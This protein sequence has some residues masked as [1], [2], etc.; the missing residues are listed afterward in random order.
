MNFP[1]L[2]NRTVKDSIVA[3]GLGKKGHNNPSFIL[4][5]GFIVNK[6]GFVLTAN[7]V[8]IEI[9][10]LLKHYPD[11]EFASFWI[12]IEHNRITVNKLICENVAIMI[13]DKDSEYYIQEEVDIALMIPKIYINTKY[14]EIKIDPLEIYSEVCI[15]GY[16]GGNNSLYIADPKK[17]YSYRFSPMML[18]GRI[19]TLIPFD[20]Q[21]PVKAI[22]TDIISTGGSSGSP[23]IDPSDAKV[24]GIATNVITGPIIGQGLFNAKYYPVTGY[25]KIGPVFGP[26]SHYFYEMVHN[27]I[28]IAN[29]EDVR[30][31][32][33][34]TNIEKLIG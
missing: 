32:I 3:I 16:P 24:I 9:K 22:Q 10:K 5:T 1:N 12:T 11:H 21:N 17:Q 7:H 18:F 29:G 33:K 19:S 8:I 23:I 30:T 15:C 27:S 34:L 31:K 4:G 25:A 28:Q 14:L 6:E 26:S 20:T 2:K 13:P